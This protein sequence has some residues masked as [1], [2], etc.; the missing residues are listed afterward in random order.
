MRQIVSQQFSKRPMQP[1]K[2]II[3]EE[4]KRQVLLLFNLAWFHWYIVICLIVAES[5]LCSAQRLQRFQ[6]PP[7][8]DIMPSNYIVQRDMVQA[9]KGT[10]MTLITLI[11][12]C[13][14]TRKAR[15]LFFQLTASFWSPYALSVCCARARATLLPAVVLRL[16]SWLQLL[17]SL[18]R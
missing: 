11:R 4:E 10:R 14:S 3:P 16:W 8:Q 13:S 17:T 9:T 1:S 12:K 7:G 18:L 5:L 6:M 2:C 15:D